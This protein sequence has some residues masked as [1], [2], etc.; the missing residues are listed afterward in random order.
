MGS[1]SRRMRRLADK[2]KVMTE[3]IKNANQAVHKAAQMAAA[4]VMREIG[5]ACEVMRE[6]GHDPADCYV[7]EQAEAWGTAYRI[8]TPE[9]KAVFSI[10]LMSVLP[11][12]GLHE[13]KDGSEEHHVLRMVTRALEPAELG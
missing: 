10:E 4:H 9:G 1:T 11:D 5:S 13:D 6:L 3:P 8:C 2:K 7:R 12:G